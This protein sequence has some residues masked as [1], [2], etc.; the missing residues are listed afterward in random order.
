MFGNR[1]NFRCFYLIYVSILMRTLVVR[2]RPGNV[3]PFGALG[4]RLAFFQEAQALSNRLFSPE[5]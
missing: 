4:E 5:N 1:A 3:D 2:V